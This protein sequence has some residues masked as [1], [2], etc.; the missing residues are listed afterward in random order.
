MRVPR[1]G[2]GHR[3]LAL[4][5]SLDEQ[6]T[7]PPSTGDNGNGRPAVD[8]APQPPLK[9]I[10][11]RIDE[12]F[13]F[14][15]TADIRWL[16][17]RGNYVRLHMPDAAFDL[18]VSLGALLQRLDPDLF[19][20]VH[21]SVAANVAAITEIRPNLSGRHVV[22]LCDGSRI[23]TSRTYRNEMRKLLYNRR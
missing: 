22:V 23:T 21:R 16:E 1:S 4:A 13:L 8:S 10:A 3:Q 11:V 2:N 17:A 9:R 12:R 5:E 18:R 6:H 14:L 19:M 20:R 7:F 15:P